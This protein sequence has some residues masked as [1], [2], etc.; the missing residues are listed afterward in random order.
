MFSTYSSIQSLNGKS[1]IAT[2]PT[3]GGSSVKV[4]SSD[5]PTVT[6]T[7]TTSTYSNGGFNYKLYK[8]TTN[9]SF[10]PTQDCSLGYVIIG[11][12]GAG[13]GTTNSSAG[14]GSAGNGSN[15]TY[16]NVNDNLTTYCK[17]G[18]TIT[19]TLGTA[20]RSWNTN[21][22]NVNGTA[23]TASTIGGSFIHPTLYAGTITASGGNGGLGSI[24]NS[25]TTLTTTANSAD[26]NPSPAV[27]LTGKTGGNGGSTSATNTD[28]VVGDAFTVDFISGSN[29]WNSSGGGTYYNAQNGKPGSYT[30]PFY[31]AKGTATSVSC[32]V[33]PVHYGCSG[34]AGSA[35]A[36]GWGSE[37][38][39]GYV[40]IAYRTL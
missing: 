4:F 6:G 7:Y 20:G 34:G 38:N 12:S 16:S 5:N 27:N 14:F 28:G 3:R 30:T 21:G 13:G 40:I 39:Q 37:G 24:T 32:D 10:T 23:G 2:V 35:G 9:G 29:R 33:N 18:D 8:F 36:N 22:H 17:T 25:P 26:T 31:G 15:L 19:I 11:A 1:N